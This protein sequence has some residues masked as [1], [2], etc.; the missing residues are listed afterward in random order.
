M[1]K[2]IPKLVKKGLNNFLL[3]A[4]LANS[5]GVLT[6]FDSNKNAWIGS[7]VAL[8]T[9]FENKV[10]AHKSMAAKTKP[11]HD[12]HL[13]YPTE[14]C[15]RS[16]S[17]LRKGLFD[18]LQ[19]C[20]AA[21]FKPADDELAGF[22]AK[23]YGD[24]GLFFFSEEDKKRVR[25]VMQGEDDSKSSKRWPHTYCIWD[26]TWPFHHQSISAF[27]RGWKLR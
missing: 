26:M 3:C 7:D 25:E 11:K 15:S 13:H 22:I 9:S 10:A 27:H 12:F 5:E 19:I 4:S 18:S 8:Q 16:K 2:K 21:Y 6:V 1:K 24:G 20:A 17:R 14:D 23:D